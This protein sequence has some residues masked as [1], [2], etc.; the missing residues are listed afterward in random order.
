MA[1]Q[2]ADKLKD[3]RIVV[4]YD[5]RGEFRPF[6][7]EVRGGPRTASKPV[8]AA[9]GDTKASLAEY[10]GSLFELRAVVE[11]YVSGDEP[12]AVV[13]YIPGVAHDSRTSVLMELEKAGR[14]WKPELKQ[15]AK[16]V[17]LQKYTLGVV[18]E[19]LPFDRKVSY[20]DLA[21][22][23]AGN[24]GAEPP[25]ILKSIFHDASGNDGL[26]TAWLVSDARDA[27]IVNKEATRELIKLVKARL[28]LDLV[29]DS[30]LTKLRAITLRYVLAG[31]FRLDLSCDA[32]ASLDSVA[33][34]P[35]KD[36]ESAVRE[37]ARRLR[38]G[39]ADAY[40]ALADRVEEELGLKNGK[41][42]AG[43]LGAIDTFRFEERALLRHAGDLIANGKFGDAL[44]LVAEREHSFWLDRD[45]GRKAQWEATRRMA[46]LGNVAIQVR[47]A[48]GKTSGD[49][50]VW[51]DAY[52]GKDGWYRLD[53][54]QR[55]LEAWIANLD[56]EPEERPLSLVRH[57]YDDACHAMA[58]GFT[59]ALVKAG[60]AVAGALH[61]TRIFS[62]VVSERPKPV[63]YF[64]VDAMRFEMGI[65]LAERV[66]KTSEVSVRAALAALPSITPIGMAALMP[67]ASASFS[68]VDEGGKLGAQIDDAFLPDL[69]T[70]RKLAA[71]RVPELV[72]LTLDELLSLQPSKLGKK[73][74][75]AQVI[76]VR[77]QEIDHAGENG[78]TFQARQVMD[79]VIDNLARALRKLATAGVE[80]AV[81]TA[82]HGH[83]FYASDRDES[84]RTDAP[85]GKTVD[86]HRRCWIGRGGDTPTGCV[87]VTAAALG[88][89]S[90]LEFV[91]PS[92][93]GVIRAGGDLAFHHGGP[94]LQEFII[95]VVTVRT[96]GNVAPRTTGSAVT[97][98][99]LP[100]AVTT[101]STSATIV[102]GGP[103][104][105]LG[106]TG[107]L[108]RPL[109][110]SGG[111]Q[112]G[113]AGLAI[114]AELDRT[115]GCVTLEPN[116]PVTVAFVLSDD[117]VKALRVVV[118]DP[119][120]DAELYR[121]PTDIPVRLG[122]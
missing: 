114:G 58:E 85:K 29:A 119:A 108:V 2:L 55:R 61:Q 84:M 44:A 71:S 62:D 106:A 113:A 8:P 12:E 52:V 49:A 89:D 121:S 79:S 78:F 117:T 90:D 118:Q 103:Q 73:L 59:K 105:V 101:R 37:L 76:V 23:A 70:R 34:P 26:L 4:W 54:A 82:D 9:V 32:P 17:L 51:I 83:L 6:V 42:P 98:T 19:I 53:Q 27:E 20:E 56:E 41:L 112:V 1:K 38:T 39:H 122:V 115:T 81:L 33:K 77:S 68:V 22:A 92:G 109:L 88:Y 45:I 96:K 24:S 7:D 11:P 21:R 57:A 86:L 15:L 28:G 111:K 102:L 75:G 14:T 93:G 46:E 16:N 87:R 74:D 47:A 66:P 25:S 120:T 100:E 36:Q 3:R 94:A 99:T 31:E 104:L 10:A 5:E 43:A 64:L 80:H 116:K 40:A 95:P 65:E 107:M 18:D 48:V 30:P 63:A 72:D 110:M 50:A 69:A 60:W 35:T 97:A 13:I 67:G 91:F